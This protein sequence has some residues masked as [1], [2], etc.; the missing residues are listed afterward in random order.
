MNAHDLQN[1]KFLLD[2]D[3]KTLRHWFSSVSED[4]KDY[5][6]ELMD[7]YSAQL[8]EEARA[9]KVEEELKQMHGLYIDAMEVIVRAQS[10]Y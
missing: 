3:E 8:A 9:E 2:A 7:R 4:D 6:I 5:A 1:L 10:H